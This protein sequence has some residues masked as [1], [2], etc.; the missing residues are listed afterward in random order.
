MTQRKRQITHSGNSGRTR[1]AARSS[2][3]GSKNV[4][5]N[6]TKA[7]ESADLSPDVVQARYRIF[8]EQSPDA[9]LISTPE[10]T[11]EEANYAGAAVFGLTPQTIRSRRAADL[12]VNPANRQAIVRMLNL[13]QPVR[14]HSVTF[15]HADGSTF[16][17]LIS[18]QIIAVPGDTGVHYLSTVRDIT[19]IKR[20]QDTLRASEERYRTTVMSVGDGVIST[21]AKG[22]VGVLNPVAELL[23]GWKQE[24]AHGKPLE[25][26]FHIINA[27]TRQSVDNPVRRVMREGRVVG[28]ANH[29]VLVS[30]DGT[31][32]PIADSGSP[33]RKEQEEITG[34]VLVFRD[35]TRERMAQ[36][37]LEAS[38]LRFRLAA[39]SLTDV[40]YEWDLKERVDWY[41]DIDGMM[42]YQTGEFPRT[43]T[44]WAALLHPDDTQSIFA[45]IDRQLKGAAPYN[46]EY[47]VKRKD[48]E[49]RWWSA[50]GTV[51][52]DVNGQPCGWIGSIT[53]ITE[54]RQT[55]ESLRKSEMHFRDLSESLPQLVWTCRGAGQCDYL[56]PQWVEYTGIPEVEQLGF[57][58]LE[59]LHPDDRDGAA[60]EWNKAV[61][62]NKPFDVEFRIR[63]KD[64]VYRW[65]KTRAIAFRDSKGQIVRWFGTSTDI[66]SLKRAEEKLRESEERFQTM[67]NSMPQLAWIAK[68]DGY[69]FWFNRRWYE[70]TGTTP[71]QMEGWGWQIVNDPA[72][73]PKV[74]ENWMGSIASGQSFE[75]SFPLRGADGR[76]RTFL[77]RV[78]PWKDSEGRVVQW[79]G[80]NTDVEELKRT[81]EATILLAA[82]VES[83][84]DAILAKD[85]NGIVTSWNAAAEKLFG[86]S[87][88]ESVGR[89]ITQIIP[90]DRLNEEEQILNSIRRGKLLDHSETVRLMKNGQLIH[91][92]LRVSPI[93][94]AVGKIVGAST[95]ARD[96]TERKRAESELRQYIDRLSVINRL[97]R[98]ISSTFE[99]DEVYDALVSEMRRLFQFD[100]TS[101]IGINDDGTEWKI[102]QQ[103][104]IG[105]SAFVP[106]TWRKSEDSVV[107]L[108]LRNKQAYVED[109]IGEGKNWPE[110]D[111][112]RKEGI[113]SRVLVPLIVKGNVIGVMTLESK[114]SNAYS[115]LDVQILESLADQVGISMHNSLMYGKV[116]D[117]A[118]TLEKRVEDRTAQLEVA[119]KEL[120]VFAYSVSHDLRAPLRHINGFIELL[121]KDQGSGV[122]EKSA[123]YLQIIFEAAKR[124]GELIDDLLSFSRMAREEIRK[125][126]LNA[127]SLVNDVVASL[128]SEIEG[129]T[130]RWMI[131]ELPMV[132]ADPAML[133]LVFV[134]LISNAQ[135]FTRTRDVAEIEIGSIKSDGKEIILFVRDNGVGFDMEYAHKLFGVFQRLH[136][137]DEFEGTGIGLANV[138][139]IISR[140]G[141]RTWA[142]G[143]VGVSA[144][145]YLSLPITT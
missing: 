17:A 84:D 114:N 95:V 117:Y 108:L 111:L 136:S 103:W 73:L 71:E 81:K 55:A 64:G 142:E 13:G 40:I 20:V 67:A 27:Q 127:T 62:S 87:A 1:K 31:E 132:T 19:E 115:K 23:T 124:M 44:A 42:G 24:E 7:L 14:D 134:N 18:I 128:R 106:G 77:T 68:A 39:E 89:S 110:T 85:L 82:I 133:K 70:Y 56:S 5:S 34:V 100:R 15:R 54:Q 21:D 2:K 48:E 38:E 9:I 104:T 119:N 97:D 58:W 79:F 57:A 69:I 83:S 126:S 49:W 92:S 35:Q 112:L 3:P 109:R 137:K 25:Q 41:G 145:F 120:E 47:R 11:I 105:E 74:M 60:A 80:T 140:H 102:I 107:G 90:Q 52:R 99:I 88:N 63:R 91:V 65:F 51:R 26:V 139:R 37:A 28:L 45:A 50:R 6:T 122:S 43:L 29:T 138:R 94:D 53:D 30:K 116:Q 72:V 135:K 131:H 123:R 66:E 16:E 32:Y 10:G 121:G 129:R 76:F 46:L 4:R 33:I 59:R 93:K 12:Y 101:L 141:G 118:R 86:Y 98:V 96:I 22:C 75:M 144:S 36:R 125:T 61:E 130:V 78:E 8:F 143:T 113:S